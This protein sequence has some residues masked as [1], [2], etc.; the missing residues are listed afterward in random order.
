MFALL[1]L[2]AAPVFAQ[3][4]S[5][6]QWSTVYTWPNVAIH[7]SLLPDGKVMSYADDDNPNYLLNGARLAGFTK[8]YLIDV[9]SMGAPG[10]STFIPNNRTNMF[11]SGHT[12]LADGRLFVVGGHLGK[13]G[14]GE[15]R[16]EFFDWRTPDQ[17]WP[18][19]DMTWGRWYPSACVLGNGDVVA[20]SGSHD[21]TIVYSSIPEVWNSSTGLW[22]QL[23][24]ANRTIPY[25][26][27]T[28]LAPDGRVF[29]AGPNPDTRFLTVTGNGSWSSAINHVLNV[30]R[31]YGSAV[32]YGD[33]KI[34]V[35]GGA[36]PPTSSAEII[37]LTA[38]T[39]AWTTTGVNA[40]HFARRQHNTTLLPDG[41]VLA[42]GGSS[43]S[44]FN[45]NAGAVL[46]PE[47]W[48]PVNGTWTNMAAMVK[49]RLYHSSTLLL[50]DGRVLSAGGGRPKADNGGVDQLNC[51]I[52]SPPYLFKGARPTITSATSFVN[53]GSDIVITT[54]DAASIAQVTMIR[55]GSSTHAFNQSQRFNRLTFSA[56]A[57]Q[58]TAT[59]P[60]SSNLMPPGYYMLFILN[61][62]GVPS[63]ATFVQVLPAG[64]VG[65]GEPPEEALLDFMALRS[66]NPMRG[67]QARIAFALSHSE[68]ARIEILDVTGRRVRVVADGFFDA[69]REQV[70]AWDGTDE[71]GQ[72]VKSGLNW[73]RLTSPSL[74]RTGKLALL[75]W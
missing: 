68:F 13:D 17:W 53:N 63:V 14:Y 19:A 40:M 21:S 30:N 20:V 23:T 2:L 33:G 67:G 37:D 64:P 12:M 43:A 5:V 31:S 7:L 34:L 39:P 29:E 73:Y 26:P 28:F 8:T 25:Y 62:T 47:L 75:S 56:Q 38:G 57:G 41:T 3:P 59:T 65:V 70:V 49:S 22:R 46:T 9:P 66:A 51:E 54:P 11:C 10:T 71:V 27:F 50:P 16:T 24:S 52:F 15:P 18:A 58:I 6:G 4:S 35:T 61:G 42:S 36:D 72:R 1:A 44:G 32:Q 45:N 74:T 69:G 55:I 60:A 48:N